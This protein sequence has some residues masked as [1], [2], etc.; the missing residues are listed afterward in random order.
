MTSTTSGLSRCEV[1]C[2]LPG[3]T[4]FDFTGSDALILEFTTMGTRLT[5]GYDAGLRERVLAEVAGLPHSE[6]AAVVGTTASA[7]R[8]RLRRARASLAADGDGGSRDLPVTADR[9]TL[10]RL[11][12]SLNDGDLRVL[13]E[14]LSEG[15]VLWTDS[16]GLTR[17]ARNPIHGPDKV[18]RF[19]GGLIAKY[20]MPELRV[21]D[22][23]GGPVV[24]AASSDMERIIT[25]EVAE[26]RITG[27]QIQQ[28][29]GKI[30][31][32]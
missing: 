16:G 4:Y 18:A 9:A 2:R 15:C 31:R 24:H 21:V 25:L 8:Q 11:A 13:V 10:D 3:M 17:A 19:L 27:L 12:S 22:A 5:D 1:P 26:G 7:T 28:N 29:P 20:G 14:Q 23:V 32:R 30:V 6:I